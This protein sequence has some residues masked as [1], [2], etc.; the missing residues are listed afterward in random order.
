MGRGAVAE[1]MDDE[2]CAAAVSVT[3]DRATGGGGAAGKA[4]GVDDED[5]AENCLR[6]V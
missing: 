3:E 4:I 2:G 1:G 5:D 6:S